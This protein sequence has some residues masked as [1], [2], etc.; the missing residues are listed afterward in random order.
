MVTKEEKHGRLHDLFH[1]SNGSRFGIP[2]KG[3]LPDQPPRSHLT[4]GQRMAD[5]LTKFC[6]SWKFI[7]IFFVLLVVWFFL[8][9]LIF[10]RHWDPYPFILL[11]LVLSC[12]AAVQAPI[13]LI[14]QNRA[15]ERDRVQNLRDYYI[16]RKA[17]RE[18]IAVINK[19]EDIHLDLKKLGIDYLHHR[20]KPVKSTKKPKR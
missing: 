5:H 10:I 9:T 8:N 13:I 4:L 16:D 7:I 2:L 14:S 19:L 1:R 12:L 15:G 17:E 18:I 3:K 6:G 20:K 11:N